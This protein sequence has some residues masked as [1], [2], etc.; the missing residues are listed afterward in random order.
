M[1]QSLTKIA[2]V[3]NEELCLSLIPT[4]ANLKLIN[5]FLDSK[6]EKYDK[7]N[8]TGGKAYKL[9]EKFSKELNVNLIDEFQ[10][11]VK[12]TECVFLLENNKDLSASLIV[13]IGTGTSIILKSEEFF[14]HLGGSALGGGFFIGIFKIFYD[15][16]DFQEAL[17]LAKTG[18]RYNIDLKVSDIYDPKDNRIDLLFREFTAASFGKIDNSFN[19]QSMKKEDLLNSVV[20]LIGENIGTMACLMAENNKVENLVFSGGFM[21]NNKILK[22]ILSLISKVNKKNAIF[23]RNSEYCGAIGAL[24]S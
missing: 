18:N 22:Q 17:N 21:K 8:F 13:T 4:Q 15:S 19:L 9:Y 6:K 11:I 12:G 16:T 3:E 24:L 10:T 23:L 14:K 2:S 7:F 1:G 20:C 5:E